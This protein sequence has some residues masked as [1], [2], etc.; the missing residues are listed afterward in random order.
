M[1]IPEDQGLMGEPQRVAEGSQFPREEE[2][3]KKTPI[4]VEKHGFEVAI[5]MESTLYSVF[6]QVARQTEKAARRMSEYLNRLAFEEVDGNLH[7]NTSS[8]TG[9]GGG[10]FTFQNITDAKKELLDDILSPNVLVVN[11][12]GENALINSDDFQRA[13]ELGDEVIREGAIGR[14]AGLDVLVDN[15]G[16]LGDANT[17]TGILADDDEYGYEVVKEDVAT[18]VYED[19]SRQSE[20]HQLYTIRQYKAIDPEA[21]IKISE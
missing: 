7:P 3:Y 6:D 13:T 14:I 18:R 15:S 10:N 16:L 9:L 12:A 4:T 5:S 1:Q 8:Y 17:P 11:T 21:A 2:D 19:E 20:I